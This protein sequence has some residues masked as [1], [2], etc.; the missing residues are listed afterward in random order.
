[1]QVES[2]IEHGTG[3]LNEDYL[4]M[5]GNMFG[6]FDG[7]TSLSPQTY[8]NGQT[9]GFLASSIAGEEFR[10][11]H[12]TM[13]ELARRANMVIREEMAQRNVDLDN[14]Q[15]L[16]STSAAVVRI[17]GDVME[18]AQIGDCRIVCVY[19]NGEFDFVCQCPDQDF[20]T[21]S[22]WKDVGPSTDEPIG[23]ALHEQIAKVR[24]RMNLDYGVFNG[25]PEAIDFLQSGKLDLS[26]VRNVLLFTDGL[27]LPNENPWE[28]RD[29]GEQV[30]LFRE[31]GLKGLRDHIRSIEATD[32]G[33]RLY[34][35]FKTHDDIAAVA[36][37]MC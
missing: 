3:A 15:D 29:F 5:E 8:E 36:I 2:L 14:K 4:L 12:G 35:R 21:L 26:G 33:C 25:E 9:G 13:E 16:W 34:P 22:I 27:L 6:V 7:A 10:K 32:L 18:W 37:N 23:V 24:C 1:M 28:E 30:D 11:N 20:E 31:S 17:H 19:E